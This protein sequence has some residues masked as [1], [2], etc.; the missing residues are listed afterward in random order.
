MS[1]RD[2]IRKEGGSSW[3]DSI[4]KED[5]PSEGTSALR[6]AEQGLTFGFA[7]EI[8]GGLEALGQAVGVKNAGSNSVAD[9]E[10]QTPVGLDLEQLKQVYLDRRDAQRSESKKAQDA[11]PKSYMA[12][13][14]G[15]AVVSSMVPGLNVARGSSVLNAAARTAAG[16]ALTGA[17]LSEA[18]SFGGVA[19]DAGVGAI[20]GAGLSVAGQKVLSPVLNKV[21]ERTGRLA[22]DVAQ[23]AMKKSP[24][25]NRLLSKGASVAGGIDEDAALR[26]IERP[27]QVAA[28]EADGF[29]YETGKK[30][31]AETEARG[32][33][34]GKNVAGEESKLVKEFRPEV[35]DG[36]QLSS[37]IDEFLEKQ[38]PSAM[39]F[40]GIDEAQRA[41]LTDLANRLRGQALFSDDLVKFRKYM[42]HV[43]KL[44]GKYD[45]EG[46]SPY[47]NFL[48]GLRGRADGMLDDTYPDFNNANKAFS[49]F[50]DDTSV[51]RSA[52]NDARAES[53]ISNLYGANKGRQQEAAERLFTPATL[54]SAKDIAS[55]KAFDTATRPGGD[56]YFRRGA[57]AVLT[58]GG[59]ELVTSPQ[60]WQKGLRMTGRLEQAVKSNPQ[61][62]GQYAQVLSNAA[63]R[64]PK[65][66]A[67]THFLLSQRDQNYRETLS[68]I[69]G[70]DK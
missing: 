61:M 1:W 6:G 31:V 51:L 3:R 67:A 59:S 33:L 36:T 38:S 18:D 68:R 48:K 45:Q 29:A 12:G 30:A 54:D 49:Q 52:T 17:G 50:K 20:A 42:D 32:D 2:S 14:V 26:Q 70:E 10:F 21:A 34:L 40:S 15:G 60:V 28:A 43:E 53:M 66:L 23:A 58:A 13:E 9:L 37:Q 63:Q 39:G 7:D 55:N 69:E 27:G 25:L 11:N 64:G 62:F 41:E 46:T 57:L 4:R 22:D 8:Q 16:G 19:Q 65:A 24:T 47:V 44:A 5:A 35:F 56:N